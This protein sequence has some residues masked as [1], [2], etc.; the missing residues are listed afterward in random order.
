[1]SRKTIGQRMRQDFAAMLAEAVRTQGPIE[2]DEI[3]R[4]HIE[5]AVTLADRAEVLRR[6]FD[7]ELAGEQRST[8]LARFGQ[9]SHHCDRQ[10]LEHAR[11][12]QAALGEPLKNR[13]RCGPGRLGGRE[14]A[15]VRV[16]ARRPSETGATAALHT[17][18]AGGTAVAGPLDVQVWAFRARARPPGEVHWWHRACGAARAGD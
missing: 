3:E 1:M 14:R 13:A 18:L 9:E 11:A 17:M 8:V 6:L 15:Q 10:A 5:Q 12:V 7:E 4:Q 16:V 2:Y